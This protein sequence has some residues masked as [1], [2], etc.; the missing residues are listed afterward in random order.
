MKKEYNIGSLK[1]IFITKIT[2]LALLF[3]VQTV[4]V[5]TQSTLF[6]IP[7]TD[8][9]PTKKVYV[10]FDFVSHLERYNNGGFQAYIPRTVVGVGKKIEVGLNV[11]FTKSATPNSVEI[12]PNIKF[13]AY[14]NEK[15]GVAVSTGAILYA[16][17]T[18]R[19]GTNTFAMLY[20]NVSKQV[21]GKYG[22]RLTGGGYGLVNRVTGAGERGGAIVGYE[23]PITDKV[24]FVA[25]WFTGKNRFGYG[26]PGI[27]I[28]TSPT[29][30]LYLGYSI[31]NSGRKNNAFFAYW[32]ITF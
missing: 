2:F 29:S 23:Q 15:K 1:S 30:A 4:P 5:F 13:Q 18:R 22:P 19:T 26:T 6:N 31:G 32:G 27:A 25:D 12:Q 14:S 24:K 3:I 10:E 28:T 9:V 11:A 16:P 7:S 20:S 21:K 8:V 17:V